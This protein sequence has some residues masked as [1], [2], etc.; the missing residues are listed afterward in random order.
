MHD[1][2]LSSSRTG[3]AQPPPPCAAARPVFFSNHPPPPHPLPIF[4][5]ATPNLLRCS[6]MCRAV[7]DSSPTRPSQFHCIPFS[8]VPFSHCRLQ[9]P[10]SRAPLLQDRGNLGRDSKTTLWGARSRRGKIRMA[11]ERGHEVQHMHRWVEHS[12]RLSMIMPTVFVQRCLQG[13]NKS[14]CITYL[15]AERI[16]CFFST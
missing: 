12:L 8:S 10:P 3:T 5:G 6:P 4:S 1:H 9:P 11:A 14:V 15:Q 16:D 2:G 13:K 7:R